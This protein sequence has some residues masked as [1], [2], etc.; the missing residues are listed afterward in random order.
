MK[1]E[2]PQEYR[3]LCNR[4]KTVVDIFRVGKT[5]SGAEFMIRESDSA[6]RA[7]AKAIVRG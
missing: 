1:K 3:I 2:K 7:M 6:K 5:K 4:Q